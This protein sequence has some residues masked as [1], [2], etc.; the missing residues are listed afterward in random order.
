MIKFNAQ[1]SESP[2]K[3]RWRII[4]IFIIYHLEDCA[5]FFI[6][7]QISAYWLGLLCSIFSLYYLNNINLLK[8][9]KFLI[10]KKTSANEVKENYK[11]LLNQNEGYDSSNNNKK[12]T[13][14]FYERAIRNCKL[15]WMILL[16]SLRIPK[17]LHCYYTWAIE[18]DSACSRAVIEIEYFHAPTPV[19]PAPSLVPE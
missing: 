14:R 9:N 11:M 19:S 17:Y 8:I 7:A 5:F 10:E 16:A 13:I 2:D 4:A 3:N 15:R 12:I 1:S 6:S 18:C